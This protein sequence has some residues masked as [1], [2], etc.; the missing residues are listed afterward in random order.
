MKEYNFYIQVT[1]NQIIYNRTNG[2]NS[3]ITFG[4]NYQ[5]ADQYLLFEKNESEIV[6]TR[7]DKN[8]KVIYS[9]TISQPGYY[10]IGGILVMK[11]PEELG[12][13]RNLYKRI[14]NPISNTKLI[15]KIDRAIKGSFE[16]TLQ[17][18]LEKDILFNIVIK[19]NSNHFNSEKENEIR[20]MIQQLGKIDLKRVT[21]SKGY[22]ELILVNEDLLTNS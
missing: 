15:F 13:I 4:E 11:R 1:K 10:L 5:I 18:T 3:R 14:K 8:R 20:N 7:F 9:K 22:H 16:I 12:L 17:R 2:R 6:I 19:I 21:E